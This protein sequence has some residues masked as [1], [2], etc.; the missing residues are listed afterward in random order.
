MQSLSVAKKLLPKI[1]F[2]LLAAMTP[3]HPCVAVTIEKIYDDGTGEGF[4]DGTD[5]AQAEKY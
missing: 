3:F 2:L 4:K 1:L 5:L